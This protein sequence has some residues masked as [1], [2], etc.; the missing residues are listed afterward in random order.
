MVVDRLTVKA[1]ARQRGVCPECTGLGSRTEVDPELVVPAEEK[2]LSEGAVAPWTNTSGAEYF[3]RLLEAVAAAAG[4]SAATPSRQL[5][6]TAKKVV[7]QGSGSRSTSPVG[8]GSGA[9]VPT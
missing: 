7:P 1:S 5:P 4:F 6:A 3:T 8:T 2:S 9:S